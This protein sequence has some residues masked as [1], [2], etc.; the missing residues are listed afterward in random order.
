MQQRKIIKE[1]IGQIREESSEKLVCFAPVNAMHFSFNGKVYACHNNNSFAYGDLRKQS[2]ND[3]WQSQNRMNMVKQLQKYKMKSVGCSQCVHD[4]VQG[5]Y[6]SVNA[7]RYEP[8]NEYHK[9]AKP[10]VLGFRFSDRCNI[11]CRMCL[12]NQN[13]RKCLAS[14]SL[15]YDDS[16]FKDLEEYIPSVKYS[17]FLGG[18]P[19]FEPLNFK[20]F[21]LFK[22][23]NPDCRISVQTNGTIFNDE[24]KSLLLEG[25]YDINVSIDSLKQDVFSSIRVGADLSKVLN[26][27]KQFLD[28]CRKNGTEFSS[29]FTPMIDNCLELPSVIDYFS[30]VLKCRIWINKY[31]FPAQFA[32]WALSPDK[33]EEIYHSLAKFKPKGN[34]EV[35][36]YNALQF[37]DFLQVIIQYKAEAIER[38]NLKQNFSK[39]VKKQLDSLRKEIKRNSSLNYEDFTQKLDLFSYTP[40]KQTY[41]FLKKLLEIFSGDKLMENIIVLNEEFIMNDIGFLEC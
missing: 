8:Y 1:Y 28:I 36:I 4:I 22:Q 32:I 31:Y 6:N 30:Q 12:S 23:L 5:N 13:V 18:E 3:I 35:S 41:Y 19:F 39:L 34:D 33:I 14:Q 20:V 17:Y 24:I 9:L 37:K 7:L 38:Q 11:K 15:V 29:C 16:F 26:N 21:K 40:S 2:L 25:K 10:S 27:S